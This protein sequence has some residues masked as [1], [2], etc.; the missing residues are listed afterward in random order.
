MRG[1]SREKRK[2]W[3]RNRKESPRI[4]KGL[5]WLDDGKPGEDDSAEDLTPW[6]ARKVPKGG[7]FSRKI[8]QGTWPCEDEMN[9]CRQKAIKKRLH[10]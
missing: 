8:F 6:A 7:Q 9:E 5:L 10:L 4:R 2:L 1:R 3:Q